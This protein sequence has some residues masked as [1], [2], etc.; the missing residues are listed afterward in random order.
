MPLIINALPCSS[1]PQHYCLEPEDTIVK[2]PPQLL[3]H[4]RPH[5]D[6]VTHLETCTHG[7]KLLLLSASSDCTVA[8]SYLPGDSI[9]LFGQVHKGTAPDIDHLSALQ[10]LDLH[11][12]TWMSEKNRF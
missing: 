2:E 10:R 6:R 12:I 4:C 9:G 7:E 11:N 5:L 3:H 8:L 1:V